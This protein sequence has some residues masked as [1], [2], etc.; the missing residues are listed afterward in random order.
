MSSSVGRIALD[1]GLRRTN[2]ERSA[3]PGHTVPEMANDPESD[4][5][6]SHLARAKSELQ[7]AVSRLGDIEVSIRQKENEI[8][9]AS[10]IGQRELGALERHVKDAE[11]LEDFALVRQVQKDAADRRSEQA[12][13]IN[14]LES[15]LGELRSARIEFDA[16]RSA[17]A[18]EV[19]R[20]ND[21]LESRGRDASQSDEQQRRANE[22]EKRLSDLE[23]E[24]SDLARRIEQFVPVVE[25]QREATTASGASELSKAY[26]QQADEYRSEWQRWL[27]YLVVATVVAL[28]GGV[29]VVLIS[30]PSDDATNGEIV[31]R[32]AVEVL[33]LG[34]LIYAV[35]LTAH[36]FRVHRHLE[37]VAVSK[38]AALSTYNRLVAG[39]GEAEVR[40]AVAVAL[41]QAVFESGASGFIDSSQDG[42]TLVE[43]FAAPVSQRLG[44]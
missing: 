3:G 4:D 17:R 41:A 27:R 9:T 6:E 37:T 40:T 14:Q 32:L 42:V 16:R 25:A 39:P 30:H 7:A 12:D 22:L 11:V 1:V 19:E 43:R 33:V 26:A 15:Q 8:E 23:T 36:Q 31:S 2:R 13:R 5:L 28:V 35:R 18:A 24:R 20:L 44:G 38:A 29:A 21:E 10:S 34:L